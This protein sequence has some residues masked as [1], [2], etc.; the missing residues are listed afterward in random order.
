MTRRRNDLE[1]WARNEGVTRQTVTNSPAERKRKHDWAPWIK[2]Q[3]TQVVAEVA[4]LDG[5]R[6]SG[7]LGARLT[8]AENLLRLPK[9]RLNPAERA[10]R[11]AAVAGLPELPDHYPHDP[12]EGIK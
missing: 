9:A 10:E 6:P 8:D 12:K 11:L 4:A 2:R 7:A 5:C 1:V 3:V